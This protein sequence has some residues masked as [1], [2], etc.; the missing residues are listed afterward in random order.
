MHTTG[1]QGRKVY[2]VNTIFANTYLHIYT[3][4][5]ARSFTSSKE[6]KIC[7]PHASYLCVKYRIR[8]NFGVRF[9]LHV[10]PY[11]HHIWNVYI[12][13]TRSYKRKFYIRVACHHQQ[14][15]NVGCFQRHSDRKMVMSR[16]PS[17]NSPSQTESNCC[18]CIKKKGYLMVWGG[19]TM[20]KR[21]SRWERHNAILIYT[22]ML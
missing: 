17:F 16:L 6:N 13:F 12:A 22:Y 3:G 14:H 20:M 18:V 11:I 10:L 21:A 2:I 9:I 5:V 15:P 19:W 8:N 7:S 4:N 1:R